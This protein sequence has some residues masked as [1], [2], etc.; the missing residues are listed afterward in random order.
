MPRTF[1]AHVVT[2]S[3]LNAAAAIYLLMG[4]AFANLFE[5]VHFL[6]PA[7]FQVTASGGLQVD[8]FLYFSFITL[9]TVGYGDVLPVSGVARMLAVT[10]ALAGQVYLVLSVSR[11]VGLH[12]AHS[13]AP[14]SGE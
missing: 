6:N 12:V 5:V 10:E 11:L 8:D 4:F 1:R 2:S 9:T 3:N 7:S 13:T 14:K